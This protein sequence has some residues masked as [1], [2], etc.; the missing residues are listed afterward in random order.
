MGRATRTEGQVLIDT[1][2]AKL[3]VGDQYCIRAL[4]MSFF[5]FAR[6]KSILKSWQVLGHVLSIVFI[7]GLLSCGSGG[8]R[9]PFTLA[10]L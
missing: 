9:P 5:D 4:T 8:K 3:Q 2:P 10:C 7:V 6:L 1:V